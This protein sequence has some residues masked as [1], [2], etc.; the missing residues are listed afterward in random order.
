MHYDGVVLKIVRDSDWSADH[1][2]AHGVTLDEV[3]E[4]ILER[5][6]WTVPG[7]DGTTLVYGRTY[8]GRHLLV[9]TIAEGEEAFV[10]TARDMTAAEKKTFRRKAQ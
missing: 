4:A 8:A 6:H 9:V 7:R 1:I 10:V 2:A 5:P 3:R